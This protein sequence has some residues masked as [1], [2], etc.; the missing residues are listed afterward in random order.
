MRIALTVSER[1]LGGNFKIKGLIFVL[2]ALVCV[3]SYLLDGHF[4]KL[5]PHT[6]GIDLVFIPSGMRL[7]VIM[8]GGIW[9]AL[10]VCVGSLFLVGSVFQTAQLLV[11]LSVAAGSGLFPYAA[12]RA[13]L[14]ATGV[15]KSLAE[16]SA[17]KL[18]LISLGVAVGSSIL[19]NVLFSALGLKPWQDL[20]E[21]S[22]AMAA[23]DFIG[24]LLAVV[25]VFVILRLI[26]RSGA[27]R[28]H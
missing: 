13:S 1:F 17:I 26:R 6:P 20:A 23:G 22:L 24:I 16:L 28:V 4:L 2:S 11:V 7:I 18:P 8:I 3:G 15:D 19:H 21:N 14:W 25:I 5:L 10:G 9:A 12:L 27:M